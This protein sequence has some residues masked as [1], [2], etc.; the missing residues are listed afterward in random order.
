M[1]IYTDGATSNNGYQNS[2]GGWA[3]AAVNEEE[4]K[5]IFF[6]SGHLE[7]TTNNRC[8]L[9]AIIQACNYAMP[10]HEE[11]TIRSD[12]AYCINCYTQGWFKNW[13][14]NGW[15]NSSRTSV[16][17]KDLWKQLIPFFENPLFSFEKVVGHANNKWNNFVDEKAVEAKQLIGG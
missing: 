15:K 17:N 13:K 3:F 5:V 12:S 9:T 10:L 14:K 6:S 8:E 4:D 7:D 11:V 2:S 1:I 16:A